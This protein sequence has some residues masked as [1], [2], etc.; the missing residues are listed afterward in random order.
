[1]LAI[2]LADEYN[3]NGI[4]DLWEKI[5]GLFKKDEP[6]PLPPAELLGRT[7]YIEN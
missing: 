5:K 3:I 2:W 7:L 6:Q 4:P 1:M